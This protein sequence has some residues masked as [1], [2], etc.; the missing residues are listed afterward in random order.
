[1]ALSVQRVTD[2]STGRLLDAGVGGPGVGV[3]VCAGKNE[4]RLC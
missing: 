2:S 4:A 3:W 1:M